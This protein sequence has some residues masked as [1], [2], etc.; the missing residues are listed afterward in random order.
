MEDVPVKQMQDFAVSGSRWGAI[1]PVLASLLSGCLNPVDV[2]DALSSGGSSGAESG[3]E[4][5]HGSGG[6]AHSADCA[7]KDT[8]VRA[9]YDEWL[10]GA[11]DFGEL[12][13]TTF[14]GY[15]E[16]G[17]GLVLVI[18]A[19]QTARVTVGE[20]VP[21]PEKDRGY[22]CGETPECYQPGPLVPGGTYPVHGAGFDAGWLTIDLHYFSPYEPWCAL[23][24]PIP[25][26]PCSF[27]I[28]AHAETHWGETCSVGETQVDCGW[29][30]LSQRSIC[31][32]TS[33]VC[34]S[35]VHDAEFVR[36]LEVRFIP[37]EDILEGSI[38]YSDGD[39]NEVSR[40]VHLSKVTD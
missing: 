18:D 30:Y 13:G 21:A 26:E 7:E 37:A 40:N 33:E 19:D 16:G 15:I 29:F 27:D 38:V 5:E 35:A 11:N 22:L 20:P 31:V 9:P 34:F 25:W 2:G 3:G 1:A 36:R 12:A 14:S 8:Q 6:A 39:G 28:A 23:Q 24:T 10:A 32:C 4:D 17:D